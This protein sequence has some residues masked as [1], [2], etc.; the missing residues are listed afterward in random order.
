MPRKKP[1]LQ[2][3]IFYIVCFAVALLFVPTTIIIL[4]GM[5]PTVAAAMVD[6][7][8][9]KYKTMTIGLLNFAGCSYS[10]LLLWT[11]GHTLDNALSIIL[12]T[13]NML[14]ILFSAAGGYMVEIA[15]T[16]LVSSVLAERAR[17][18]IKSIEKRQKELEIKWGEEVSG[19]L[20]LDDNGF[21]VKNSGEPSFE[22]TINL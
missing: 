2:L 5:A 1:T 3:K 13:Q 4:C 9:R 10:L 16:G 14:I 8:K 20:A 17:G 7:S 15:M 22:S 12:N 21:P 18:R 6:I 19:R 11:T